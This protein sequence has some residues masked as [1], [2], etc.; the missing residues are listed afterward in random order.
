MNIAAF[1]K[2]HK[3]SMRAFAE[4]AGLSHNTIWLTKNKKNPTSRRV[5]DLIVKASG[6]EITYK[7]LGFIYM[8]E[9]WVHPNRLCD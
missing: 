6:G 5:A 8:N 2:K 3:I 4:C 9:K 7:D 1:L